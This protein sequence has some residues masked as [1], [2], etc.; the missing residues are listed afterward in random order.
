MNK[1]TFDN[2]IKVPVLNVNRKLRVHENF[3]DM[4]DYMAAQFGD[5]AAY[6][7]KT[8]R[9]TKSAPAEYRHVSFKDL[10]QEVADTGTELMKMGLKGKRMAIIGKNRY[11]WMLGY[12]AHLCGLGIVVPL[13][14]GLPYEELELSLQKSQSDVLLFDKDHLEFV[15]TLMRANRTQVKLFICMDEIEGFPCL[16]SIL[17]RG[18]S[19]SE[20][21]KAE[22]RSL[23]IDSRGLSIILFTSGTS[24]LAKAV[25]LSQYN[26]GFNIW[27]VL[28]TE[29]LRHGDVNM[30]FL[31]YHHTFGSTGQSMMSCCGMT[32]VFCDGLKYIQKNMVEYKVSVFICV[33]LIIESMY[34][35]ILAGVKKQGKEETFAKGRKIAHA[36][37][38]LHIDVRRRLFKEVLEQLGGG[39]R[40]V[41]SGASPL[42]PEVSRGFKDMGVEVIQGYGLTETSPV[43]AGENPQHRRDGSIGHAMPGQE[44]RIIDAN[45]DGI[46]ELIAKGDNVMLGYYENQEATDEVIETAPDGSRW[47][48]T[49][50][51]AS[52]DKDGYLYIRG[53]KKNVIVLKNGKNVYPEELETLI[54]NFPYVKEVMVFGE[55]KHE[56]GPDDDLALS[57]RIV[58]DPEYMKTIYGAETQ[59]A[60]DTVVKKD[61]DILNDG[62]PSYKHIYRHEATDT[63]MEMTT[64]GKVKRYKEL[65][66]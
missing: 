35:K 50:D 31:P 40:Y 42:D 32:T 66:K 59:E 3:R 30:A 21:E 10:R 17:E 22:Y 53:R 58:Y 16:P 45:E 6:I 52:I 47:F 19:A 64:T 2:A 33:P 55:K 24:G 57:V 12:Y 23:P 36:L 61:L 54:A 5:D 60:V 49:G 28:C 7:I 4:L 29:D 51:L 48:H 13:D 56:D 46:G 38:K 20:A 18:K 11:E 62:L 37:K 43:L 65:Q 39:L 25:M 26:I 9:E 1:E 41:I 63:P 8:K 27:Q 14:K 44:L 34:K 15:E